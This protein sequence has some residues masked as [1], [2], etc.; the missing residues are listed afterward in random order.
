MDL[1]IQSIEELAKLLEK[2]GKSSNS[3]IFYDF[4]FA[5]DSINLEWMKELFLKNM[6]GSKAHGSEKY[7]SKVVLFL[8]QTI[9]NSES[10]KL[11][12]LS[13]LR[14]YGNHTMDRKKEKNLSP[15]MRIK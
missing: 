10:L 8:I 13:S 7:K 2:I 1:V 5:S 11:S 4:H 12:I 3:D 9:F 6:E 15:Q 14:P